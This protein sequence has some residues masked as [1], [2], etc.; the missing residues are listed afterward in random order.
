ML[1]VAGLSLR[2]LKPRVWDQDSLYYLPQVGAVMVSY[3]D[4]AQMPG[5]RRKAVERGLHESLG[6]PRKV[7]IYLDNGAFSFLRRNDVFPFSEYEEFVR[8]AEPDWYPIPRDFIP[9]PAMSLEDQREF[10]NKTMEVNRSYRND[11][12]VPVIHAGVLIEDYIQAVEE[13]E[14]LAAKPAIG[15]GGLVPNLLRAPKALPYQEI[16]D[17]LRQVRNRFKYKQ[18]HL[19]GVGGTATLHLAAL[20]GADSLDSS[21]WRNRAARGIVQL[22]GRGDRMV[23]DLGSW[24]GRVPDAVEWEM[25]ESCMCPA[26]R[27]FGIAGLR[28]RR[29]HGFMNRATHN[30]WTLL[31]EARLIKHHLAKGTYREWYGDH[32]EN[33]SYRPLIDYLLSSD[34]NSRSLD[35]CESD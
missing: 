16:L 12:Y 19:F 33:S 24:S 13:N 34:T 18:L 25:L 22:P 17:G 5:R 11:G 28:A 29:I 8:T 4:F 7:P 26:C 35:T 31:E 2:N 20:L 30:L 23:V 1:V 6:I 15:L 3:A 9:S 27:K 14:G 32:V 21:G 10:L